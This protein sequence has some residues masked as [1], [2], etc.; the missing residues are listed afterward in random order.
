MTTR[1]LTRP[2]IVVLGAGIAVMLAVGVLGAIGSLSN[3]E[4]QYGTSTAFG[5]VAAGEGVTLILGLVAVG[6]TLLGQ[7]VPPLLRTGLWVLPGAAAVMAVTAANGLGEQIVYGLTPMAM[8]GAAE[9]VA[10]LAR[11]I[12][13]FTEGFD[14]DAEAR[15]AEAVRALAYHQARAASHPG[16]LARWRSERLVWRLAARVGAGDQTLGA[17]LITVQRARMTAGADAALGGMYGAASA[18]AALTGGRDHD[19]VTLERHGVTTSVRHD[20]TVHADA[21][22]H[23]PHTPLDQH[24][25]TESVRPSLGVVRDDRTPRRSIAADVREMVADGVCDIRHVL[26][27]IATRHGRDPEDK[28]LRDTVS[29]YVRQAQQGDEQALTGSGPY[30]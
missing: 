5:A 29:R 28:T 23:P 25:Q 6:V 14:A 11:R 3:L 7:G 16:R 15:S 10:F 17:D 1:Q 26:D 12:V 8:T 4:G 22:G 30:L 18:P 20:A 27:A 19:V 9:G 24:G 2:K 13:V 21:A